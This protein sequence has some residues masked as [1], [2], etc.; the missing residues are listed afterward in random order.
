MVNI[1]QYFEQLSN[2]LLKGIS[3]LVNEDGVRAEFQSSVG[4]FLL[5]A[6]FSFK[7]IIPSEYIKA[8]THLVP[9]IIIML[10]LLFVSFGQTF[11][12]IFDKEKIRLIFSFLACLT[13]GGLALVGCLAAFNALIVPVSISIF[14]AQALVFTHLEVS[15]ES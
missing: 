7:D 6:W 2:I 12:N 8:L 13:W 3:R 1:R 14:V 15:K 5:A 4:L 9:Q 11:S 10:W